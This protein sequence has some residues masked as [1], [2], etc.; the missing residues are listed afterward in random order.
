ME[1]GLEEIGPVEIMPTTPPP[2]QPPPA[3]KRRGR[4]K[5]TGIPPPPPPPHPEEQFPQ[6]HEPFPIERAGIE[7]VHLPPAPA[8]HTPSENGEQEQPPPQYDLSEPQLNVLPFS[9]G[10][11]AIEEP[12]KKDPKR[13]NL[14][15][16][17]M[18]YK[19][20]FAALRSV[21]IDPAASV[22]DLEGV[23]ERFRVVVNSKSAHAV[24]K[25][26]Y[27]GIT[28][29]AETLTCMGG[30]KTQG[31]TDVLAKSEHV[32]ILLRQIE[33]EH[34]VGENL[35]P[36]H[37]LGITSLMTGVSIHMLNVKSEALAL[38]GAAPVRAEIHEEYKD[39]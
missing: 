28:K 5:K 24:V 15:K 22:E 1:E 19:D 37:Q 38:F 29:L 12:L 21:E 23:V 3:K 18:R 32:D 39:L 4:P 30:L 34:G 20:K 9:V 7:V 14:I 36:F 26:T 6:T 31:W 16:I 8:S 11:T 27:L 35:S 33:A 13:A 10:E 17:I 25:G 2:E